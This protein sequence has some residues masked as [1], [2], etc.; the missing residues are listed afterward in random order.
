M[1]VDI[2]PAVP[3]VA[4]RTSEAW[5]RRDRRL[6]WIANAVTAVTA[7]VAIMIVAT[8]AVMLGIT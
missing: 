3:G 8:A 4:P 7:A 2:R 1:R 5:A 6:R